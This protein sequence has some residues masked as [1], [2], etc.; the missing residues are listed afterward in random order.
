MWVFLGLAAIVLIFIPESPR[1]YAVKGME[2]QCK[3]TLMSINGSVPGYDVEHEYSII[4]KEIEDGRRLADRANE[5]S[6]WDCFRGT[7]LVSKLIGTFAH[8]Q[9]RT[10]ISLVPLT[11]QLWIGSPVIF[12][13]TSSVPHIWSALDQLNSDGIDT[14]SSSRAWRSR[15]SLPLP[16]S[17]YTWNGSLE[18]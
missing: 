17:E 15:S 16:S 14:F 6:V 18:M 11:Y 2:A 9:R 3:K 1:Y 13:Y 7:N 12:S 10:F 8:L 5:A 4:A